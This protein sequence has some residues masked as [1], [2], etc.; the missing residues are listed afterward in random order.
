MN[1]TEAYNSYEKYIE[2]KLK[3]QSIRTIKNRFENHIINFFKNYNIY[4]IKEIDIINWQNEIESKNLSDKYKQTLHTALVSFLNFCM[5]FYELNK[6]VASKVGNFKRKNIKNKQYEF[7]NYEEFN[8]FIKY[9]DNE[10][11]KQFFNFMF[12]V[13]TRPGETLALKFSD[14]KDDM[15][16]INKT[17]DSR[18]YKG[19][20]I[21]NS[22][23]TLSSIREIEIDKQ[24]KKDL[25]ELKK[26]YEKKYNNKKYDYFIFG[27]IKPLATTTINRYK[28][29]ACI[30]ANIK[31]I[32]LHDFRHSHATLLVNQ[33]IMINEISR[34]LGHSN[35]TI[36]LNTYVHTDKEQEK[37]VI[38]TLNSIRL[39]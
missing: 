15:I 25:L 21:E 11:Y 35:V 30:K 16:S 9:V 29:K 1:F 36:T 17:L 18:Y 14:L 24:L 8:K 12:F 23:K 5:I 32:R 31:K 27:G 37:K 33:N 38:K 19:Q 6:N 2:L 3:A 10:I 22:P 20:R 7:Y 26:Y 4:N 34:R 28:E 13:G 39:N